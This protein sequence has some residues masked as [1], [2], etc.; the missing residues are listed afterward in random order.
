MWSVG[1]GGVRAEVQVSK[2]ELHTHV[3]LHYDRVQFLFCIKNKKKF[4]LFQ[5][6]KEPQKHIYYSMSHNA[7]NDIDR[8]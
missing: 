3:H 6:M 1:G 5:M 4:A 8:R 2:M 7:M